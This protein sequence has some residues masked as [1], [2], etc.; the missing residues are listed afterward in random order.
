MNI[1]C[2]GALKTQTMENNAFQDFNLTTQNMI[3]R[4]LLRMM[5]II[6]EVTIN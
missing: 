5:R 4:P 1:F 2:L 3:K 6:G